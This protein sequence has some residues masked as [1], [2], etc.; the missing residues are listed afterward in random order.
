MTYSIASPNGDLVVYFADAA[1]MD[2]VPN[3]SVDLVVTSPPYGVG[4]RYGVPG[5]TPGLNDTGYSGTK[6]QVERPVMS[7]EDYGE[8]LRWLEPVWRE[9]YR[10]M[11]PGA[12]AALNVASIHAKSEYFG[13]S[14]VL[15]TSEDTS[16]FWRFKLEAEYR[17]RY[18]WLAMR[19]NTNGTDNPPVFFGSYPLPLEGQILRQVE[20]ILI[21]R[22]PRPEGW[23]MP[24]ERKERRKLSKLS[25]EDW[26][27]TFSQVWEFP[28]ARSETSNGTTHP[29]VF[30]IELPLRLI[31]G[32]S[33]IG[34]T[35]LD[36]FLGTGTTLLAAKTT[37][38]R[39]IGYEVERTYEPLII[40]KLSLGEA[41]L[42]A[43]W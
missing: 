33:C 20:D 26:R 38:R 23:E 15:P 39:G 9:T 29:A 11:K 2:E 40:S 35:V 19:S 32:Y 17:W 4:L 21:F 27:T 25:K 5:A 34:D 12:Y 28:G 8:Y 22:K 30:P 3:E 7:M 24:E 1:W 37:G 18:L 31:R 41:S 14:F 16:N 43:E 6:G 42:G 10:K 36:P 13:H